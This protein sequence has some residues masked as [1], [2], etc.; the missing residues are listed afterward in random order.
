MKL[1]DLEPAYDVIERCIR[2]ILR[3]AY[4]PTLLDDQFLLSNASQIR[5]NAHPP[6]AEVGLCDFAP[7]DLDAL[8]DPEIESD[9]ANRTQ[10]YRST[11]PF[12]IPLY[13]F[14]SR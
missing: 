9:F 1:I 6:H 14:R 7:Q 10:T 13:M 12:G 8:L 11:S 5:T 3:L 2:E 4:T